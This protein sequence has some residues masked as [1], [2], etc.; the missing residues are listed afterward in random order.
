[1][2]LPLSL[3]VCTGSHTSYSKSTTNQAQN[4]TWVQVVVMLFELPHNHLVPAFLLVLSENTFK[5]STN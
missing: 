3:S 2:S 5:N 1:M 4:V